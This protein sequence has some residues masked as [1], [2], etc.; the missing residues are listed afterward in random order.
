MATL[1]LTG[2]DL[3]PGYGVVCLSC[4]REHANPTRI[5]VIDLSRPVIDLSQRPQGIVFGIVEVNRPQPSVPAFTG[6]D[7]ATPGAEKT[8]TI[9]YQKANMDDEELAT[10]INRF[11][12][13]G[14]RIKKVVLH[15]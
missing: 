7:L 13:S 8:F 6:I 12:D 3:R 10:F 4:G 14:N 15:F 5:A 11:D 9:D 2:R 1:D